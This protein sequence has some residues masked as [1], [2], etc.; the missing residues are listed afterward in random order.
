MMNI[1]IRVT[2]FKSVGSHSSHVL[3][4]RELC[5]TSIYIANTAV[6]NRR[7]SIHQPTTH[8]YRNA[9]ILVLIVKACIPTKRLRSLYNIALLSKKYCITKEVNSLNIPYIKYLL[10]G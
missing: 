10:L 8:T 7:R 5:E 9:V 4:A 1:S 6:E 3:Y 2:Y